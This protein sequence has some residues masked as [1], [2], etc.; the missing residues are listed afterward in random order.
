MGNSRR[1][2]SSLTLNDGDGWRVVGGVGVGG[3]W[4][5]KAVCASLCGKAH[6]CRQHRPP[7]E[8]APQELI[9]RALEVVGERAAMG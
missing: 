1:D 6:L 8:C 3:G 7:G 4:M 2:I 5:R 9:E